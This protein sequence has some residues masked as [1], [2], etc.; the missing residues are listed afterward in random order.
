MATR[1]RDE[2]PA[3]LL[4]EEQERLRRET[5][6]AVRLEGEMMRRL[7]QHG[8]RG[9]EEMVELHERLRRAADAIALPEIDFALARIGSLSDRL[10]LLRQRLDRLASLRRAVGTG[11]E[12]VVPDGKP[13]IVAAGP[14]ART[15]PGP[16]RNGHG[17]GGD[18]G[19]GAR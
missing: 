14:S 10:R 4:P 16:G 9:V 11:A 6:A 13:S 12:Q 18:P 3:G 7:A 2:A 19:A 1:Q 17:N 5:D 15:A 8:L